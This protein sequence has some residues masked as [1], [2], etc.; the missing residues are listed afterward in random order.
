VSE[1]T[2]ALTCLDLTLQQHGANDFFFLWFLTVCDS[3]VLRFLSVYESAVVQARQLECPDESLLPFY[4]ERIKQQPTNP[5][6]WR[7]LPPLTSQYCWNQC[8]M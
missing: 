7:L 5:N 8:D 1:V 3:A 2:R 6:A 4:K